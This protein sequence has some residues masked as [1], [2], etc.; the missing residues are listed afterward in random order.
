MW[1]DEYLYRIDPRPHAGGMS[2]WLPSIVHQVPWPLF[3]WMPNEI[4]KYRE[5]ERVIRLK[6]HL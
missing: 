4:R 1:I 5:A 3:G 2:N 6:H